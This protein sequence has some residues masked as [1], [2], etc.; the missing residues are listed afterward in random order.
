MA[1]SLQHGLI[2]ASLHCEQP[3]PEIPWGDNGVQ[4]N[5]RATGW[6]ADV[7]AIAGVSSF[8]ISGTNAHVVLQQAAPRADHQPAE[9][10]G[11]H[12]IAL[13]AQN[14]AALRALAASWSTRLGDAPADPAVSGVTL[15]DV[16]FT[17]ASRRTPHDR[18][19]VA[20]A[21]TRAELLEQLDACAR[22]EAHAAVVTG[23][24]IPDR[25]HKTA[26]VFPGQGSQWLGMGRRLLAEQPAFRD[27]LQACDAAIRVETG[28]SVLEQLAADAAVSR[29]T[30]IDVI[31]PVLF[32]VQ[33]AL[34]ALWRVWGVE[35]DAVVGHSMGEVAASYVA[36]AITLEDAARVICRRSQLLKRTSGKGAMAV[37]GLSFDAAAEAISGLEDRLSIAVSNSSRSTVL[38]GDPDAIDLVIATLERRDIFCRRVKVDVAS[39]SPQMD[40]LQADLFAA[41]TEVRPRA[42][43]VPICSTVLADTVDGA[44]FDAGYWVRNLRQPVLFSRAVQQLIAAGYDTFVEMSPHPLL[45]SSVQELLQEAGAEGIVAGSLTRDADDMAAIGRSVAALWTSGRTVRLARLCPPGRVA[46]LPT[47]PFQREHHWLDVAATHSTS[48]ALRSDESL[49]GTRLPSPVPSFE[50]ECALDTDDWSTGVRYDGAAVLAPGTLLAI[51]A[52]AARQQ[53]GSAAVTLAR[54]TFDDT[55]VVPA[56]GALYL[57][58]VLPRLTRDSGSFSMHSR[59]EADAATWTQCVSGEFRAAAAGDRRTIALDELRA[60]GARADGASVY[61]ALAARGVDVREDRQTIRETFW[62]GTGRL[63]R[64]EIDAHGDQRLAQVFEACLHLLAASADDAAPFLRVPSSVATL[65]LSASAGEATQLLVTTADDGTRAGCLLLDA[66]GQVC[67]EMTDIELRRVRTA[68]FAGTVRARTASWMYDL[69]WEAVTPEAG[70]QAR[71]ARTYVVLG[72]DSPVGA[73]VAE[74]LEAHGATAIRAIP[75]SRFAP[76]SSGTFEIDP[77][78]AADY[79][80]VLNEVSRT[81]ALPLAGIVHVASGAAQPADALSALTAARALEEAGIPGAVCYVT[82]GAQAIDGSET[83]DVAHAAVWG[84]AR[85]LALEQPR[86][87]GGVI[88]LDPDATVHAN[89]DAVVAFIAG[90]TERQLA[91]RAGAWLAPRLVSA[92][93]RPTRRVP[94]ERN[95]AYVVTGGLGRLGLQVARWL[96]ENGAGHIVLVGRRGLPPREQWADLA[97]RSDAARQVRGVAA[98]ERLGAQVTVIAADASDATAMRE[99]F[100]RFGASLPALR[101]VVHAAGRIDYRPIEQIGATEFADVSRAK[102]DGTL[103][104]DA[105]TR[106]GRHALDFFVLF[107]SGASVWGSR[108]LAHYSAANHVLDAVAHA[109]RAAGFP[110]TAINWGWWEGGA[111]TADAEALFAQAGLQVMTTDDALEA[112]ADVV[113]AGVPQRIVAAIDW[114]TF[115]PA[116]ESTGSTLLVRIGTMAETATAVRPRG[117]L[118]RELEALSPDEAR[119]RILEYVR[120]EVGVVIGRDPAL[121]D[122]TRGLF[123]LGMDSLMTVEL[124]RRLEAALDRTLPAT[125]AFEYPNI[126]ALAAFLAGKVVSSER[127]AEPAAVPEAIGAALDAESDEDLALMLDSELDR[128][129][130]EEERTN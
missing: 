94:L 39:H 5:R 57:Q 62:S 122:P 96:A 56:D 105:L 4:V 28:W 38:S 130:T 31:Q 113:A 106:D 53:A 74:A 27:A 93:T 19:A 107:S 89:A 21:S 24:S 22:G 65:T 16:A 82:A 29:L 97:D 85:A 100:S 58:T 12:F 99:L 88:D 102:V 90:G 126:A 8:G 61:R 84:V 75:G 32:S 119:A 17:A 103:V 11:P 3:N 83:P 51:A 2:P 9:S 81:A 44:A 68:A 123:K 26:F 48:P 110:A 49:L 50:L 15:S 42:G 54:M 116:L 1:L 63:A 71:L 25:R 128:L 35:P 67:G 112:M 108:H 77:A 47:Y 41:L 40:P 36:G 69:V 111:T 52:A 118:S 14:D 76:G 115:K 117:T 114:Q 98:V 34:A 33:V 129:L 18:R 70:E 45:A 127:A 95:A 7:P 101:G 46:A 104:L 30:E 37:V 121:L 87:F 55:V 60:P 125:I 6:A 10:G 64:L 66:A 78:N 109:R 59:T 124:R 72:A 13:S 92:P 80:R 79:V 20:V 91:R 73:A 86:L 23:V 43:Q 120:A